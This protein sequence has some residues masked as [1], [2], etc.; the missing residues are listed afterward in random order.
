MLAD[1]TRRH[2]YTVN[3]KQT[4][5]E[6]NIILGPQLEPL[7]IILI[8]ETDSALIVLKQVENMSTIA[9]SPCFPQIVN[10]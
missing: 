1:R 8:T 3:Q 2:L 10:K 5:S 4:Q 9:T 6:D 7:P